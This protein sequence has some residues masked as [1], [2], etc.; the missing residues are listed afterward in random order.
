M[1]MTPY[2]IF[3][4][5][6]ILPILCWM[7]G[8]IFDLPLNIHQTISCCLIVFITNMFRTP[9]LQSCYSFNQINYIFWGMTPSY[10]GIQLHIY[11]IIFSISSCVSQ[12]YLRMA[13]VYSNAKGAQKVPEN[14]SLNFKMKSSV[15][16]S[17]TNWE[18]ENTNYRLHGFSTTKS[19]LDVLNTSQPHQ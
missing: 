15:H 7:H 8:T 11:T 4:L 13:L 6:S 2:S 18:N 14:W 16:S 9:R 1:S 19:N 12:S 3:V 5:L 17:L 10:T